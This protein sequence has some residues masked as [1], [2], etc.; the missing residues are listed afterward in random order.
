MDDIILFNC[1]FWMIYCVIVVVV[2]LVVVVVVFMVVV[3]LFYCGW[4]LK[5]QTFRHFVCFPLIWLG[6]LWYFI[7]SRIDNQLSLNCIPQLS[8]PPHPRLHI[9]FLTPAMTVIDMSSSLYIVDVFDWVWIFDSIWM[10]NQHRIWMCLFG[11]RS[12]FYSS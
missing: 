2:W 10:L 3:L 8:I 7:Y 5:K 6:I 11:F 12:L 4:V 1:L 9:Y